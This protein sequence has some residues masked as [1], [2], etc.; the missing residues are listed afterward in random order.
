MIMPLCYLPP[1]PSEQT[2]SGFT[3]AVPPAIPFVDHKIL[4]TSPHPPPL[5]RRHC[6]GR[7]LSSSPP[8][9]PT[10]TY[11]PSRTIPVPTP[12]H[13]FRQRLFK[14]GWYIV[15]RRSLYPVAEQ[16]VLPSPHEYINPHPHLF[17]SSL[18][19]SSTP[20]GPP[21][22]VSFS[23]LFIMTSITTSFSLFSISISSEYTVT[24]TSPPKAGSKRPRATPDDD[25]TSWQ[26]R[27]PAERLLFS[28]RSTATR[29]TTSG[30]LRTSSDNVHLG[31][32]VHPNST[33]IPSRS[34]K[35]A[36]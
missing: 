31:C 36:L 10:P 30:C 16:M 8:L 18:L 13:F 2:P 14:H 21:T 26:P 27:S 9:P 1:M 34:Q 11:S 20:T 35:H 33:Q 12:F 7:L 32:T 23:Y 22:L 17:P 6:K 25:D 4:A 5:D 19:S 29:R 3:S 24:M 15:Q 28:T